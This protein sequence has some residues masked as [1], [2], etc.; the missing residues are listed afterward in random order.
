MA[1]MAPADDVPFGVSLSVGDDGRP[2]RALLDEARALRVA[3]VA[4]DIR[5]V[6]RELGAPEPAVP[7]DPP[8]IDGLAFGLLE[9]EEE[10]LQ[11]AYTLARETFDA[12][13]RHW[14]TGASL[15]ALT[16][17][18][19]TR[20]VAIDAITAPDLVAWSDA[21]L[22]YAARVAAACG[23]RRL[24]TTASPAAPRR[25]APGAQRHGLRLGLAID[26]STSARDHHDLLQ[27]D[28]LVDLI[29]AVDAQA[30]DGPDWW[31][32]ALE[33]HDGRLAYVLLRNAHAAGDVVTDA[34]RR[35]LHAMR[36]RADA[37]P[38][39]LEIA[40]S[41]DAWPDD[42]ERVLAAC[43]SVLEDRATRP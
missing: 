11:D 33:A 30:P 12:R 9:L 13:R 16:S 29:L 22:D 23:A 5:L 36:A 1:I 7:L 19:T 2:L 43:R 26:A 35:L 6:E 20:G 21:E 15:A 3:S 25:I 40:A 27:A 24:A 14:R 38:L 37:L 31:S 42:A 17:L 28:P 39:S 18:R 41:T 32:A 34:T 10:V 4:V 8:T